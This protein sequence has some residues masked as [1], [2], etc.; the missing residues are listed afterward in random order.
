MAEALAAELGLQLVHQSYL[1]NLVLETDCLT[2]THKL[3][4]A[5]DIHAEIGVVCR[6]IRK[7][8]RETGNGTWQYVPREGN[9]AAHIM[10]HTET[11]WNEREVWLD[12]PL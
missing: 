12:R 6:N 7:L 8:L 9:M 11:R 5:D 4:M 3:A 2:L 10:A 1:T